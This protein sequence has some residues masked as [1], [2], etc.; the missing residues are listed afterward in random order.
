[1]TVRENP[2]SSMSLVPSWLD[3]RAIVMDVDG[4]LTDGGIYLD[5]AGTEFKRYDVRDGLGISMWH[6]AG[7]KTGVI[8]GRQGLAVTHRMRELRIGAFEQGTSDK[9][10]ALDQITARLGVTREQCAFVGDD[11]PDLAV[12]RVAGV[13]V[14]VADA[15]NEIRAVAQITTVA[16]GGHGAVR[17]L[18]EMILR[19]QGKWDALVAAY[20]AD[21]PTIIQ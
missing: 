9:V 12:M 20:V 10:A 17:E 16:K 18:I 8:T 6:R 11:L 14:A 2:K 7:G 4:T 21:S 5:D 15:P 3:I 19:A 1:M 13:A